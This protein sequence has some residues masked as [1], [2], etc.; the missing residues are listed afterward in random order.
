MIHEALD[1][2]FAM[3][4]RNPID[5][6]GDLWMEWQSVLHDRENFG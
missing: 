3:S 1:N 2:S 5:Q 4:A 6:Y